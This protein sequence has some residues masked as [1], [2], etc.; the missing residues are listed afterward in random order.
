MSLCLGEHANHDTT[1]AVEQTDVTTKHSLKTE[2]K[3]NKH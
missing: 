1:N 3:H 2:Q